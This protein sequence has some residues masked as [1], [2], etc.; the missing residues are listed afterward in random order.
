MAE[1]TELKAV[2]ADAGGGHGS[3]L[4]VSPSFAISKGSVCVCVC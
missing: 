1:P 4:I 3:L 2:G